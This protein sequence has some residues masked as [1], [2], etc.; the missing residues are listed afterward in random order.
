MFSS[1]NRLGPRQ[2]ICQVL[3]TAVLGKRRGGEWGEGEEEGRRD[4]ERGRPV[5]E[6]GEKI[7]KRRK[8]S[9]VERVKER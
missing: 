1:I 4:R 8:R 6:E 3:V 5:E 7:G 2:A 9:G